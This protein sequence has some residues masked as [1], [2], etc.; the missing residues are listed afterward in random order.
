MVQIQC[1]VLKYI[2][3]HDKL[4]FDSDEMS[5]K[6]ELNINLTELQG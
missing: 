6:N 2:I 4:K 5:G 3:L 1:N